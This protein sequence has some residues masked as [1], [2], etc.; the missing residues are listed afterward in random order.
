MNAIL[1]IFIALSFGIMLFV[2]IQPEI[3]D[4]LS[5]LKG[6]PAKSAPSKLNDGM[7]M[8]NNNVKLTVVNSEDLVELSFP[9]ET[10][11]LISNIS[12]LCHKGELDA[13]VTT[14]AQTTGTT[15]TSVKVNSVI[16]KWNKG[17]DSVIFPHSPAKFSRDLL[18]QD[19]LELR[20]SQLDGIKEEKIDVSPMTAAIKSVPTK[21][22]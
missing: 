7:Y 20:L 17:N 21:C 6:T 14:I 15:V 22:W 8:V 1:W 2:S 4:E 5:V 9:V 10:S 12:L 13:K 3:P 16:E 18:R 11:E 19:P